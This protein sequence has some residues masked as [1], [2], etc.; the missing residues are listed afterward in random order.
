[1]G[2]VNSASSVRRY[3]AAAVM[4]S[5]IVLTAVPT[6][7]TSAV[8]VRNAGQLVADYKKLNVEAERS[9]EAMHNATIERRHSTSSIRRPRDSSSSRAA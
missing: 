4:V 9:A 6:S 1:M 2:I 5:S 8:P 7:I 3:A